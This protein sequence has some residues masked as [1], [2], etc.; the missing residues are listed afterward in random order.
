[1]QMQ[2]EYMIASAPSLPSHLQLLPVPVM[3]A[4]ETTTTK[5]KKRTT[6]SPATI[7]VEQ[8]TT[9]ENAEQKSIVN[10]KK[11]SI[12]IPEP[13]TQQALTLQ[14]TPS[15]SPTIGLLI[16]PGSFFA[17]D[18]LNFFAT[19]R[20]GAGGNFTPTSWAWQSSPRFA[21]PRSAILEYQ[22]SDYPAV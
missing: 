7:K 12:T 9:T 21:S 3:P 17:D 1:M 20:A 13:P 11:L 5:K 8:P 6:S 16:S 15:Q 4:P 19:P 2:M 14:P 10:R 22:P 18:N